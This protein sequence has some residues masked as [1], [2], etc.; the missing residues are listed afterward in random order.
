MLTQSDQEALEEQ[1]LAP[2]AMKSRMTRGREH[3]IVADGIR[4]DFQ[5]DR[6]RIIHCAAFRKLEY[7][8]QV[9][10]IHEG[11]YYRTRLTHTL[12]V[13]QIGRSLA[14]NLRLNVDLAEAIALAH[15]LGHTPFGH[16][17]ERALRRLMADHGGFEHNAQGLRVVERLE[18][19]YP[20]FPGL[21]LTWEVREGIIK[22]TTCYDHPA[23][24][25]FDPDLSPT[26]ESQIIEVADEIAFNSHDIDDALAMGLIEAEDLREVP[27]LWELWERARAAC[28]DARGSDSIKY[29]ALGQLIEMQMLDVLKATEANLEQAGIRS[30]E[31]VRA[32]RRRLVTFSPGVAANSAVLRD[33]LMR[34]VYRHP[35]VVRMITKAEE[36]VERLFNLY[37]R[38]PEQLPLDCQA[39][40]ETDGVHRVI[41]DYISGMTDRF[42]LEDFARA[43]EPTLYLR[44]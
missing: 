8:S 5:R 9:Y 32:A 14:R 1:T 19:R 33:F 2:Y 42:L 25:R 30:I 35:R 21:N 7:K 20:E 17:G 39:Q 22:H 29:R 12:E 38:V 31:D 24:N 43:F 34:R 16:S 23:V 44:G 36:F 37:C 6:D 18:R 11:D 40:I 15:D 4:T 13:A 3:P 10:F 41:A 26:L 27:W 28:P